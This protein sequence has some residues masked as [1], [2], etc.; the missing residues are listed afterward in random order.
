MSRPLIALGRAVGLEFILLGRKKAEKVSF[1]AWWWAWD[2]AP[3]T[4]N[5]RLV[6]VI[7]DAP[8]VRSALHKKFHGEPSSQAVTV[9]ASPMSAPLS[10]IGMAVSLTY[11]A[12]HLNSN[13]AGANY[14]HHFGAFT[15]D[16]LPPFDERYYPDVVVDR[17]GQLMLKRKAGNAFRLEDWLIG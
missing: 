2:G 4:G 15:H 9:N 1:P 16:D 10:V 13:K 12:Q 6:K 11:D 3:N 17:S 5:I 7:G 8:P 14:C